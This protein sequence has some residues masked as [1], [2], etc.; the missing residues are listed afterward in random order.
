MKKIEKYALIWKVDQNEGSLHL[1]LKGDETAQMLIDSAAEA[2][3]VLDMLRNEAPVYADPEH[4][5][6]TT[7]LEPAGEGEG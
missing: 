4:N 7:G 1:T 5:L 3:L 6:L 2:S